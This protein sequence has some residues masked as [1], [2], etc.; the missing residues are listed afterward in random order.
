[1]YEQIKF[2]LPGTSPNEFICWMHI[3]EKVN[4][5]WEQQ[6]PL[7]KYIYFSKLHLYKVIVLRKVL[8]G[9]VCFNLA[10]KSESYLVERITH[11]QFQI[12]FI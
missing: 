7:H 8:V 11:L 12:N 5:K 3:F 10:D 9:I 1:M 6:I 4:V 2:K